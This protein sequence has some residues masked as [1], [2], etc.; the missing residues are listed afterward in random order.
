[1]FSDR[2]SHYNFAFA[3]WILSAMTAFAQGG[4]IRIGRLLADPLGVDQKNEQLTLINTS[5]S[6]IDLR[7]WT[8][9]DN[10]N[11]IQLTGTIEPQGT[12]STKLKTGT[13][14]AFLDNTGD[15][16]S[17]YDHKGRIQD[18]IRYS[19]DQVRAGEWIVFFELARNQEKT[20][21]TGTSWV[22]ALAILI[23]AS[24][25]WLWRSLKKARKKAERNDAIQATRLWIK[26]NPETIFS[27]SAMIAAGKAS[28]GYIRK[29]QFVEIAEA[30]GQD[31]GFNELRV[32]LLPENDPARGQVED[33]RDFLQEY[34]RKRIQLNQI[35]IANETVA[36]SEFFEHVEN[37]PL[38]GRQ[39]QAVLVNEENNLVIAGAGSGKT[40]TITA[41]VGYL[42][43][44]GLAAPENILVLAFNKAAAAELSER[45]EPIAGSG[46]SAMTFHKFGLNV[47]SEALG[48]KP[49]IANAEEDSLGKKL[50]I[51]D[52][53]KEACQNEAF[54]KQLLRYFKYYLVPY[55][56]LTSFKNQEE[57]INYLTKY[58]LRSLK[59]EKVKSYGELL[60]ANFLYLNGVDY[61]Y[62]AKY[63]HNT[64]SRHRRQYKPDFYLLKAGIY[65]EYLALDRQGNTPSYINKDKYTDDLEW[66]RRLHKTKSTELVE[67]M[68]YHTMEKNLETELDR[69]LKQHGV[70]YQPISPKQAFDR[71]N[72]LGEITSF[73]SLI[74]SF[75]SHFKSNNW[76]FDG[77]REKAKRHQFPER[78]LAFVGIFQ[79]LYNEYQRRLEDLGSIDFDDM[80]RNA[81]NCLESGKTQPACSRFTHI[82][83]D[84]FQDISKGRARLLLA[85][86]KHGPAKTLF[87]VGDDWQSINRFAGSDLSIMR[88]FEDTFG[89]SETTALDKTFRYNNLITEFT[90]NFVLKNP[91]QIRKEIS[92]P[93]TVE[94][95]Q[96]F[97]II[98]NEKESVLLEQ[99][100]QHINDQNLE[101][102]K[103]VLVLGR[104]RDLKPHDFKSLAN[105]FPEFSLTFR[106]VHG[107]KGLQAD[108]VIVLGMN[109]GKYGFPCQRIDDPVM[110]L[111]LPEAEEFEYAEE[112][113]LFYVACTRTKNTLY[114][115]NGIPE[116]GRTQSAPAPSAFLR[117][118]QAMNKYV[119]P[120]TD[121]YVPHKPCPGDCQ[122][123]GVLM[124]R[125]G[126]YGSFWAC[127][128]P[129][130]DY[131]LKVKD[132]M[133]SK[134]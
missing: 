48:K 51:H 108:H 134:A 32:D 12:L 26:N 118:A 45:I 52:I 92:S 57:Y 21:N 24:A 117:E 119:R 2:Y 49:D 37:D 18:Q 53:I 54:A 20:S 50:K 62:E 81:V 121:N 8:L 6:S 14:Y 130:C 75:L 77:L 22:L 72:K 10:Y 3:I 34:E 101:N 132:G 59:G 28:K 107:S 102:V 105:Q 123:I 71:I 83:V 106:T 125:T 25:A 85:L 124:H 93:R 9:R 27:Y 38:T 23:I 19:E 65:I 16:I 5:D 95:P 58:E 91:N 61:E 35:F 44:R 128:L 104:Y 66:K 1:M 15:T 30:I 70:E 90:T 73:A 84:E 46:V 99:A 97:V 79:T 11:E 74:H 63:E 110:E 33:I 129:H 131:I 122:G 13:K 47:I 39:R 133:H 94:T 96:V 41:R 42:V 29:K 80:I 98:D 76:T 7:G 69:H 100:L 116:K 55:Q 111:V 68:C 78:S 60:I 17:L 88:E 109:S 31:K 120:L 126:P 112:R 64:A 127:S 67:I 115:I 103:S 40:S 87:C 82:L 56:D 113:R 89:N 114:L 36:M 43:K 4:D 86:K